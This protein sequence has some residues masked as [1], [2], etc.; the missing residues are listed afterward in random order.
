MAKLY[1]EPSEIMTSVAMLMKP[2]KLDEYSKNFQGLV[3]FLKEGEKLAKSNKVEYGTTADKGEFL[4]AFNPTD[5]DFLREA[6]IGISAAKSIRNWV[7][8]RS[9]ETGVPITNPVCDKVYLT[10]DTWPEAVQKFQVEAFG[11]KS[12]NSSDIIF[13]WKENYYGVSLKKKPTITSQ[14][15]TLINKA[16][17][18]VLQGSKFNKI[19]KEVVMAREKYFAKVVREAFKEKILTT[20]NGVLPG[21]DKGLMSISLKEKP[22]KNRR[23][24]DL[25]GRGGIDFKNLEKSDRSIFGPITKDPKTSMRAFV[26]KKLKSQD[27]V[28]N[29]LVKV[30]N[31]YSDEFATALLNLVLKAKLFEFLDKSTFAFALV[32]GVAK[33]DSKGNPT[34]QVDRAK[35]LHTVL[36]GLGAL[37]KGPDYEMILD[38][39]ANAKSDGAKV[40]LKLIKGKITVL[41]MELRYKG[42]FTSQPQFFAT[43][44]DDFKTVLYEKCMIP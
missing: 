9:R 42:S 17:D 1:V 25:K 28:F 4:K 6:A 21:D 44:A 10:G 41:N 16:F 22:G 37:N 30:M 12:Y 31:K 7:P 26:N 29:V 15:P 24:I 2:S 38:K 34:I 36:C 13:Q 33:I 23:L 5:K 20:L 32:T 8:G 43:L 39:E 18:S 11:F 40:F 19:K 3:D 27:S 14:D 35:G